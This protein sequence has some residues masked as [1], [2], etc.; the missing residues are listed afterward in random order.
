MENAARQELYT[1]ELAQ[2]QTL[3]VRAL[4]AEIRLHARRLRA[5]YEEMLM[6]HGLRERFPDIQGLDLVAFCETR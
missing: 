5:K 6:E 3:L 1:N 2:W 4:E